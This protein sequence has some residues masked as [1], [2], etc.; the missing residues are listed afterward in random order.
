MDAGDEFLAAEREA[1]RRQLPCLCIDLDMDRLCS[2]FAAAAIPYPSN[3]MPL[4]SQFQVITSKTR[5]VRKS[6][7]SWLSVPRHALRISFPYRCAAPSN[8][9]RNEPFLES[10]DTPRPLPGMF[11]ALFDRPLT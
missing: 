11:E 10:Q 1:R 6:L 2:R 9:P 3:L 8:V 5:I 7:W 4:G